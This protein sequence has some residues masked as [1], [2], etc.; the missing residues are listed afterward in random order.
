MRKANAMQSVTFLNNHIPTDLKI[1]TVLEQRPMILTFIQGR[2]C[3][4]MNIH[5]VAQISCMFL[6]YKIH[7][8]L[9]QPLILYHYFTFEPFT[10]RVHNYIS[11]T[12]FEW[13]LMNGIVVVLSCLLV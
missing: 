3:W 6:L 2:R 11:G 10:V 5:S 7:T 9:V 1:T 8:T 12:K 13:R 4:T